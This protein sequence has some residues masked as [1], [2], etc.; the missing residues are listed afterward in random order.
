MVMCGVTSGNVSRETLK[1]S[2]I[3]WLE[4]NAIHKPLTSRLVYS[5]GISVTIDSGIHRFFLLMVFGT[6]VIPLNGSSDFALQHKY[7]R[8]G[9]MGLGINVISLHDS[10]GSVLLRFTS[11]PQHLSLS[12][13]VGG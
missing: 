5:V 7:M 3:P 1:K 11:I 6:D 9:L 4:P 13:K 2:V 8:G 10:L 12:L